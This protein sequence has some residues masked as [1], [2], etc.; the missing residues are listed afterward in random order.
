MELMDTNY[1]APRRPAEAEGST[2]V[3]SW[4]ARVFR[5]GF[6]L[7][8]LVQAALLYLQVPGTSDAV[9]FP[10]IDKVVHAAIFALPTALAVLGRVRP[11]IVAVILAAHAPV[12]ELVQHYAI[13]GRFGDPLDMLADW[14]GILIGLAVG[15]GLMAVLDRTRRRRR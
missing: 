14:A 10:H 6:V 8:M 7:A 9:L 11:W 5:A 13:P 1:A 12:S 3:R 2:G 4:P 15:R